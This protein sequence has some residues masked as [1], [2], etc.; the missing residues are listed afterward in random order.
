MNLLT[1]I[2]K[3]LSIAP[4][5]VISPTTA[6]NDILFV[7]KVNRKKYKYKNVVEIE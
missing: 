6:D 1:R 2:K 7:Q 3:Y 5:D 4:V